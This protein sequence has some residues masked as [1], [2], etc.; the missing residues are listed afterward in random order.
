MKNFFILFISLVCLYNNV[1][2][3]TAGRVF[4]QGNYNFFTMTDLKNFQQ[5]LLTDLTDQGLDAKI[6]DSY[7]AYYGLKAGL[8]V[9]VTKYPAKEILV[10]GFIDFS[11]TGARIHYSDYSGEVI[12]DQKVNA[13]SLGAVVSFC[14]YE[15]DFFQLYF[16][17]NARFIFSRFKNEF[18]T[19]L[20]NQTEQQNLV[21][22]AV[23]F[24]LEPALVPSVN[25]YPFNFGL[26]V[27]YMIA[28]PT[29]LEYEAYAG[30][31]LVNKNGDEVTINWSGFKLGLVAKYLF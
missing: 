8:L 19:K 29:T 17:V 13:V 14:T 26:A 2:S 20:F 24:G 23:S 1:Q 28:L 16:D 10:G 15:N 4:V 27:S 9:P 6:T 3:Q 30:A 25:V 7:P 22:K 31:N 21:F 11:A 18:T 12:I 5:E